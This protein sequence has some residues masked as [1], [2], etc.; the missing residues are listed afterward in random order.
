MNTKTTP[1]KSDWY[2]AENLTAQEEYERG[3]SVDSAN[4]KSDFGSYK[5]ALHGAKESLIE[6]HNCT[7]ERATIFSQ[8]LKTITRKH[9]YVRRSGRIADMGSVLGFV[10]AEVHKE[11]RNHVVECYEISSDAVE[12]GKK[13]FPYLSFYKKAIL[14]D[15]SFEKKFDII[16]AKEFY[17]F[18]RTNDYSQQKSFIDNFIKNL[19]NGGILIITAAESAECLLNNLINLRKDFPNLSVEV[20]PK[21]PIYRMLKN[22][23]TSQ[24]LTNIIAKLLRKKL[25][26]ILII[27]NE[28]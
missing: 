19:N 24:I 10:A 18:T 3:L 5:L 13:H 25:S 16:Y 17:P 2:R 14:S 6:E 28:T 21:F 1:P 20:E 22:L 23:K 27:K 12:F 15:S 8:I 9:G 11:F 26:K 4:P 7:G